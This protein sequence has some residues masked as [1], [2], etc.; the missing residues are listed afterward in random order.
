MKAK[1]EKLNLSDDWELRV[2]S[3]QELKD[4]ILAIRRQRDIEWCWAFIRKGVLDVDGRV[5]NSAFYAFKNLRVLAL[6]AGLL[7]GSEYEDAFDLK[8]LLELDQLTREVEDKKIASCLF[9][10]ICELHC[11]VFE[12]KAF[13]NGMQSEYAGIMDAAMSN[14]R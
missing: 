12:T 13:R 1:I 14:K 3:Y 5:R 9:R 6:V 7:P 10:C 2:L 8:M 4:A 11:I